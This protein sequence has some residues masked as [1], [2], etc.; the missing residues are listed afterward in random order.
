MKA[1]ITKNF[2]SIPPYLSTSWM[3]VSSIHAE[4]HLTV[5]V[6]YNGE[7]IELPSLNEEIIQQLFDMHALHLEEEQDATLKQFTTPPDQ[8][9]KQ[10]PFSQLFFSQ[11]PGTD[12]QLK[13]G[14]SGI[15][16]MGVALQHNTAY[17]NAPDL[18]PEVLQ[19]I[20]SIGK[21]IINDDSSTMPK[22]E[23]H[24]NC[25]FCQISR[26]LHSAIDSEKPVST[27][28]A[29]DP[30]EVVSN[31]ELQFQNWDIAQTGDKLF[32]VSNRLDTLET[33]NVFLGQPVGCTCG[34]TGCEHILAVL[35]S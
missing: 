2:I 30:E 3:N 28:A 33:Y 11:E 12:S 1:K 16:G 35:K 18:P 8:L 15:D 17:A 27:V 34:K 19:K 31:E 20:S 24:C 4:G 25:P 23:P 21:I 5:I 10:P 14:L 26:A 6:L 13:F 29:A 7:I 9:I 32:T 22:P